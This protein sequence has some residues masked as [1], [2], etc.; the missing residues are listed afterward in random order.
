VI[1]V[2]ALMRKILG[3][4]IM[5]KMRNENIRMALNLTNT[6]V[7]KVYERQ[8][9]WL[10]TYRPNGLHGR[11]EGTPRRDTQEQHD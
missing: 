10:Q 6:I 11:V 8:H 5:D 7:K 1:E 9:K 3:I 4:H 2:A